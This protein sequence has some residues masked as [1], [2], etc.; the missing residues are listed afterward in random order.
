MTPEKATAMAE[1]ASLAWGGFATPP[2]LIRNR[3]NVVFEVSFRSGTRAA[4]RLHRQGYQSRDAIEAELIWTEALANSGFPCPTP[5]LTED[6]ARVMSQGSDPLVSVVSWIDADPIG[7]NG[8]PYDGPLNLYEDLGQLIGRLHRNT[9]ALNLP[10]LA[11]PSWN[12]DAL[13]GDTPHWG[14]FWENP[15]LTQKEVAFLQEARKNAAQHFSYENP[16]VGLIH[17]D[18][19][20]ENILRNSDGL[21]II[22]FDDSGYGYAGY[23]I[24]TALIQHSESP[25]LPELQEALLHGYAAQHPTQNL[26]V[27]DIALYVMLR[28]MASCGW[29][30]LRAEKDDPRQRFYAER[31]LTCA[32]AY[33]AVC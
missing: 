10:K 19:L 27:K 11:R 2:R 3:E 28:S 13:L 12:A 30:M 32:R 14:R 24:G 21:W 18:L 6:G 25:R 26:Q 4:L 23:D 29:I 17:A 7:E 1:R 33:L 5:F 8:V 20:Q 16:A 9:A 15:S 22:D 31:A